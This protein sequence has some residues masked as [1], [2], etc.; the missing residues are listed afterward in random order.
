MSREARGRI[1]EGSRLVIIEWSSNGHNGAAA[2][3][4][5]DGMKS[6]GLLDRRKDHAKASGRISLFV[7]GNGAAILSPEALPVIG[8][9]FGP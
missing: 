7:R 9:G 5:K 6:G 8:D 4:G 3:F 2:A 1:V